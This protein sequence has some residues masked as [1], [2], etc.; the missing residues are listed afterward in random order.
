[1]DKYSEKDLIFLGKRFNNKKRKF[2]LINPLQAKHLPVSPNECV[3]MLEHIGNKVSYQ[4]PNVKLVIG[5]AET[6]TAV[7]FL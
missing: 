5:F 3:S 4:Y 7:G 6:A 2:L 1:M